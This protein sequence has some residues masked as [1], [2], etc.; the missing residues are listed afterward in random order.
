MLRNMVAQ[1]SPAEQLPALY[2]AVLAGVE[3]LERRDRRSQAAAIRR[4]AIRAYSEAWDDRHRG[5]MIGLVDRLH[6][7]LD[8]GTAPMSTTVERRWTLLS[9]RE[10]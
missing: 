10:R 7:E 4:E 6:K 2:R 5:L 1:L 8:R 3:A 9:S